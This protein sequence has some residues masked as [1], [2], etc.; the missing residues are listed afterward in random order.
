[1]QG[2][3]RLSFALLLLSLF[4]CLASGSNEERR[5]VAEF[6]RA[7]LLYF[8]VRVRCTM[9]SLKKVRVRYLICRW[10]SCLHFWY[11]NGE[12]MFFLRIST[13]CGSY[14]FQ[15]ASGQCISSFYRCNGY[16]NCHDCSDES[17]CSKFS[18]PCLHLICVM[19]LQV[20]CIGRLVNILKHLDLKLSY[21]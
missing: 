5:P 21:S 9:L 11:S 18:L 19:Q 12:I 8:V 14:Q 16:C 13:A 17:T 10:A 15:C 20:Q 2:I 1:M 6:M 4:W 7:C 3:Y